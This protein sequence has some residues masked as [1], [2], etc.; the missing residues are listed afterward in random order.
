MICL[1]RNIKI[2]TIL[3]L[4][5]LFATSGL[6]YT[7]LLGRFMLRNYTALLSLCSEINIKAVAVSCY[8]DCREA[9]SG[10]L[11]T[12]HLLRIVNDAVMQ[13][14]LL[15]EQIL[16]AGNRLPCWRS[17]VEPGH[18]AAIM[19]SLLELRGS[20]EEKSGKKMDPLFH[21]K[22]DE[23]SG[24]LMRQAGDLQMEIRQDVDHCLK[25]YFIVKVIII[26]SMV[27]AGVSVGRLHRRASK[28]VEAREADFT[29]SNRR[30]TELTGRLRM[31]MASVPDIIMEV[32][33]NRIYTWANQAGYDFFGPD[34]IGRDVSC[35]FDGT[36]QDYGV[37]E[38]LFE[39]SQE[40]VYVES[41]QR[42]RDGQVRL[43]AWCC[44]ALKDADGNVTGVL[45]SARDVTSEHLSM[46]EREATVKLLGLI[47]SSGD[48]HEVLKLI[49]VYLHQWSGCS[50][51]GIRIREGDDC[52]YYET[53]GFPSDFVRKETHLCVMGAD[54]SVLKDEA[55]RP[56]LE[57]MCGNII[58]GRFDPSL[59]FF[60]EYGSFWTN[61]T[62]DLLASTSEEDRQAH[63]RNRCNSEGYESV[64]LVPL[65][66]DNKVLGLLQFNDKKKNRFSA[67]K[68]VYLESVAKNLAAGLS[69]KQLQS[70]L[71]KSEEKFRTL[72]NN[73]NIGIYRN[74]GGPEGRFLEA[75]PAIV[76]MF[77]YSSQEEFMRVSVSSL[78]QE[79]GDRA[80]FAA[81][82]KA[83]GFVT[84]MELRLR[85]KDGS[86]L[87]G[88][89]TAVARYD[90]AGQLLWF[91]GVMEDITGRKEVERQAAESRQQYKELVENTPDIIMQFDLEGRHIFA[92]RSVNGLL[93]GLKAES[94]IGKTHRELGFPPEQCELWEKA[95]SRVVESGHPFET[96]FDVEVKN[97]VKKFN[98]RLVPAFDD[99]GQVRAVLSIARDITAHRVAEER[100]KEVVNSMQDGLAVHEMIWD[101]HGSP[102]D[103]RFL[104][105][106]PAFEKLTG[107]QASSIVG[108]TVLEILPKTER[109]WI[110][111][112]GR[113]VKTG[114]PQTVE[115]YSV[116]LG[117]YFRVAAYRSEPGRFVAVFSDITH[118]KE[119]EKQKENMIQQDK[120][121]SLGTLVAGVAH[122]INNPNSFIMLNAPNLQDMWDDLVS[123]AEQYCSEKGTD[124]IGLSSLSELKEVGPRLFSDIL[125]GAE[126]IKT[127]VSELKTFARQDQGHIIEPIDVNSVIKSAISL[128]HN[129]IKNS[130][131]R[132][133][134]SYSAKLPPVT[135]NYQRLEQVVINLLM[136]AC[137][138]LE[139]RTKG[140]HV[141]TDSDEDRLIVIVRVRDEGVGMTPE[142]MKKIMDP[143]FTTKRGRGGTGLGLSISSTIVNEHGGA[144]SYDSEPGRGT[145]ATLVLEAAGEKAQYAVPG[146]DV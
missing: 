42:R 10:S 134:V 27:M 104:A 26:L 71:E 122:E 92:S 11:D 121:A 94:F 146:S 139:N 100:Y 133:T 61:S 117:K 60:T 83:K 45:S 48:S 50:A 86:L 62:T 142:V 25:S 18:A 15:E 4:Y 76:K 37:V 137:D 5:L 90:A 106:N 59:P 17:S 28:A 119:A 19:A 77:G 91:D 107:L 144:L 116:E 113:I 43:L 44:R 9:D 95:I 136:N 98:W 138:A 105:V 16:S 114:I 47:S 69:H 124:R 24:L 14:E 118:M 145:T 108:K 56:V 41:W 74:T 21:E 63:T 35:Y 52:P 101:E 135:G 67:E 6:V 40:D 7:G 22:A 31:I 57:C 99:N 103:Y 81:D 126:R 120:L 87:W 110:E 80:A 123:V 72:V 96:E 66:Y 141:E 89:C 109:R 112:Y 55:G 39:G 102:V 130:T 12:E 30:L 125:K 23:S 129:R 29:E 143:F 127:I 64:A 115:N 34:V 97:G 85:R 75:N 32:D 38:P 78:Y 13:A 36:E 128:V 79:P 82:L 58:S 132:F 3:V 68:I 20:L 93:E 1:T 84:A 131:D 49:T 111:T 51:V 2:Y 140:I 88:S 33:K 8:L 65:K 70:E 54:G 53:S 46:K 73:I